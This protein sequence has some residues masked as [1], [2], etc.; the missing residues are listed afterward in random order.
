MRQIVFDT[1]TTGFYA[2][3]DDRIVEIGAIEIKNYMPT[4]KTFHVYLNPENKILSTETIAVHGLTNE[5]LK[6]KPKFSEIAQD[7]LNFIADSELVAHNSKFDEGFINMELA[8]AGFSIIEK[9]RFVDT[10][11]IAKRKF[12][13]AKNNL[14]ALCS[15][16]NIDNSHR[17]KHG[18]LLDAE[19]LADVYLEL[20]G[21]AQAD[22]MMDDNKKSVTSQ[23]YNLNHN[24]KEI[25]ERHFPLSTDEEKAH[26]DFLEVN[27]SLVWNS[28][29]TS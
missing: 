22:F 20:V 16:F 18:A 1:E 27:S 28:L 25:P 3:N 7:F 6:D 10:L 9:H 2:Q 19:L 12:P 15:R 26:K 23:N 24:K 5:F 29:Q 11:E 8:K 21:G 17:T 14:D 13:G 4:G